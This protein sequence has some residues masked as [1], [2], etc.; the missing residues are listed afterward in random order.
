MAESSMN[1]GKD[2]MTG[3]FLAGHKY[4]GKSPGSP[5]AMRMGELR[6]AILEATTEDEARAAFRKLYEVAM[7][8]EVPALALYLAY[9]AGKPVE[10]IQMSGPD[11]EALGMTVESLTRVV[12][13][14]LKGHPEAKLAVADALG[15]VDDIP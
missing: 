1:N 15:N 12:L 4:G 2:P 7:T 10:S 5:V 13:M 3:R 6:R 11:G 14:A 8:G 9:V